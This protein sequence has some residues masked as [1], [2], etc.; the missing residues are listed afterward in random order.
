MFKIIISFSLIVMIALNLSACSSNANNIKALNDKIHNK[1]KSMKFNDYFKTNK[2]LRKSIEISGINNFN[3]N[4]STNSVNNTIVSTSNRLKSLNNEQNLT[5]PSLL[6]KNKKFII[7]KGK[8]YV[9]TSQGKAGKLL[10][11]YK[12]PSVFSENIK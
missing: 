5:L 4:L 12:T 2:T 7:P 6:N 1:F 11:T 9:I 3:N 10:A 8:G